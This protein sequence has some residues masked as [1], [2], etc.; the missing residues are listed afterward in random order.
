MLELA[1]PPDISVSALV[2]ILLVLTDSA[3]V[4]EYLT[5]AYIKDLQG[6][7]QRRVQQSPPIHNA[8]PLTYPDVKS[9]LFL[10]YRIREDGEG[11]NTQRLSVIVDVSL[12]LALEIHYYSKFTDTLDFFVLKF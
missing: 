4:T 1:S 3:A 8:Y 12:T 2:D 11:E 6:T 7:H 10:N 5:M 9:T